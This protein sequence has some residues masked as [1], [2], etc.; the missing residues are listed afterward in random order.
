MSLYSC[1]G[2]ASQTDPS[3]VQFFPPVMM[4]TQSRLDVSPPSA[5]QLELENICRDLQ[6]QVLNM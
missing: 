3:V 5:K 4:T 6:T 1:S 2:P